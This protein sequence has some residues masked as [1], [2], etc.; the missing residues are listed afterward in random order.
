MGLHARIKPILDVSARS[1]RQ[2]PP[3][4]ASQRLRRAR[5]GEHRNVE[6]GRALLF[7]GVRGARFRDA[8]EDSCPRV[9]QST[10]HNALQVAD[11]RSVSRST[12]ARSFRL[13]GRPSDRMELLASLD[14]AAHTWK[15]YPSPGHE[16]GER[17]ERRRAARSRQTFGRT[18]DPHDARARAARGERALERL[19]N[20]ALDG[21]PAPAEPAADA[22]SVRDADLPRRAAA[23]PSAFPFATS[24]ARGHT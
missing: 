23:S 11:S 16:K 3:L 7:I 10:P 2:G 17:L 12:M 21:H 24:T 18:H 14:R 9:N 6:D 4:P 20:A 13:H 5:A 19:S 1:R 8:S 22:S 15:R